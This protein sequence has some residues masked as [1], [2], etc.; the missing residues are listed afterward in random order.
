[1]L[2]FAIRLICAGD[3]R[4]T[5]SLSALTAQLSYLEA[6]SSQIL[7]NGFERL[8]ELGALETRRSKA[9]K[10]VPL[11]SLAPD[12]TPSRADDGTL[13]PRGRLWD[14]LDR[15]SAFRREGKNR[16]D[17]ST[18]SAR[19]LALANVRRRGRIGLT[20]AG[21]LADDRRRV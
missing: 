7:A 18:V 14:L 9:A 16:R 8:T 3:V 4:R 15:L 20:C 17:S 5:L 2:F 13:Q 11:V 21:R 1:M 12:W 19:V 6:A 10:S